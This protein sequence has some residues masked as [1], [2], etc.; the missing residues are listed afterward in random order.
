MAATATKPTR[1][2][3][4]AARL[5]DPD[6]VSGAKIFWWAGAGLSA[7]INFVI[8]GYLSLYA[9]DTLALTPATIGLVIAASQIFNA[10]GGLI[11][12]WIVDRSPETKRGKAR[13]YEFAVPLIWLGT[14]ALFSVP[15]GL[16]S[17]GRTIWIA[18]CFIL[19]NGVFDPLLRAN[20][21]LYMARAFPTRRTYAKVQTRAGII[22]LLFILPAT[23]AL[24]GLLN[25]A[26]KDPARWSMTIMGFAVILGIVGLSRYF[27]VKEVYRSVD[28]S[29]P[30]IKVSEMVAAVKNNKWIWVYSAVPMLAAAVTGANVASYYWRY[31]VGNLALQGMLAAIGF[32]ILP[33]ML[34]FPWLMKRFAVSQIVLAGA[35]LG[36]VGNTIAA[37]AWGNLPILVV[38][39]VISA[40]SL[41][42]TSYLGAVM[43]LDLCTYNEWKGHRRLESTISALT[44]IF[45][46]LGNAIAAALVGFVLSAAGYDGTLAEQ[47]PSA[48]RAINALTYWMPVTIFVLLAITM[49]IYGRFDRQLLPQIQAEVDARRID[50]G[51]RPATGMADTN[52]DGALSADELPVPAMGIGAQGLPVDT[53]PTQNVGVAVDDPETHR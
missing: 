13:P 20:D 44:G 19:I 49:L 51:L 23:I 8:L 18:V 9:T 10:I 14:V 37:F 43:I 29:E 46:K 17:M 11:A 38:G 12:A 16:D 36:I 32:I 50:L 26:G 3:R 7:A 1:A 31:I 33:I 40:M 30:P 25:A 53:H 2:E 45:S 47:S 24:P 52:A 27:G 15:T 35:T 39:G 48:M 5:N 22:Q 34:L 42:P 41:M 28:D 21:T 6:H 4:R